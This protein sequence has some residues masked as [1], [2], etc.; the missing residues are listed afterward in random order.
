MT[1]RFSMA[2]F[3]KFLTE[4]EQYEL[5][6]QPTGLCLIINNKTFPGDGKKIPENVRY[7][8]DK[9]AESLADVFTWLGFRVLMCKDQTKDQMER[10]LKCF[11]SQWGPYSAAGVQGPGVDSQ[12]IHQTSRGS[13]AWRCLHLLCSQSWGKGCGIGG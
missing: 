12:R 10:A 4:D 6:S 13:S 1:S 5:K 3:L 9:D 2:D 11:A 8:T 7:G